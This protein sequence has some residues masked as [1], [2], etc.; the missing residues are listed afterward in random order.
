MRKKNVLIIYYSQTGQQKEILNSLCHPLLHDENTH[1]DFL[2]IEPTKPYPF[3]WDIQVFLD[4]FPESHQQIPCDLQPISEEYLNT[5]YDLVI[6]SYQV[7]YLTPSIPINS[8]LRSKEAQIL[9][10]NRPVLTLVSCRNMWFMAQEKMKLLLNNLQAKHIGHI[11]LS[12]KN[13]N[14]I[15]LVTIL[16]WVQTGRKDKKWGI[17]PRPGVSDQDIQESNKFGAPVLNALQKGNFSSLHTDLLKLGSIPIRPLL[18]FIDKRG[19]F[20][21]SKWSKLIRSKGGPGEESRQKY[22]KFFYIYLSIALWVIAPLVAIL[23]YIFYLPFL[24]FILKEKK[25]FKSLQF[26]KS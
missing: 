23:Y 14:H 17:F 21:F 13:W 22:V 10:K 26:K 3:P 20:I 18:I 24:P 8:F 4:T 16:H 25:Y 11:A 15:S 2:K 19:N 5:P 12:D 9:L 1:V 7:W 6:L